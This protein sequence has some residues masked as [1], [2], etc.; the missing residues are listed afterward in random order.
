MIA[1]DRGKHPGRRGS[2]NGG[3]RQHPVRGYRHSV[4]LE[5]EDTGCSICTEPGQEGK[6]ALRWH[7]LLAE[8]KE[9]ASCSS[10]GQEGGMWSSWATVCSESQSHLSLPIHVVSREG[11]GLDRRDL[12][13]FIW[14]PWSLL[15]SWVPGEC[16]S[17]PS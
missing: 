7:G 4:W 11:N 12:G 13:S 9:T 8:Q 16:S 17:F 1:G 2:V 10:C 14:G 5:G 3:T 6:Q 15:Q